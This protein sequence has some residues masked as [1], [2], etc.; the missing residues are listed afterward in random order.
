MFLEA[1]RARDATKLSRADYE[2]AAR[3]LEIDEWE[4]IGAVAKVEAERGAYGPDGL[5]TVL[6]ERHKFKEFTAGAHDGAHPDL[7]NRAAGGYGDGKHATAWTRLKRA[8]ALD[9][10]A[11]LRATSWGQFQMMGFNHH[12]TGHS[13]AHALVAFLAESEANQLAVFMQYVRF[14]GLIEALR[15]HNWRAFAAGYNGPGYERGEYHIK[16]EREYRRLKGT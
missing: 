14:N 7:S 9:G 10:E 15:K 6:F 4:V 11:A 12:M 8:Y 16:M 5:P 3:E 13:D 2:R 1:L